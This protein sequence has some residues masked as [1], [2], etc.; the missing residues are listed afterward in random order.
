MS[1]PLQ[2]RFDLQGSQGRN[3]W[4]GASGI[5]GNGLGRKA[6]QGSNPKSGLHESSYRGCRTASK[7]ES[8]LQ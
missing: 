3:I 1:L 7:T 6:D 8:K 5:H 4:S 2:M